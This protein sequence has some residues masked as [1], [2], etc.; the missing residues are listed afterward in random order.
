MAIPAVFH[1][2]PLQLFLME[3]APLMKLHG[4]N[5][6]VRLQKK[7]EDNSFSQVFSGAEFTEVGAGQ[8]WLVDLKRRQ[9]RIASAFLFFEFGRI[10]DKHGLQSHFTLCW[11]TIL[12]FSVPGTLIARSPVEW[13]GGPLVCRRNCS[14]CGSSSWNIW[15]R[16]VLW[17]RFG[18]TWLCRSDSR[19]R[20]G[21]LVWQWFVKVTRKITET[22]FV[23]GRN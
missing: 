6:L 23:G 1:L 12:R 10:A 15:S 8:L 9:F 19:S 5:Q 14:S 21:M 2:T 18:G 22:L 7:S 4:S 13:K 11:K 16:L 20:S 17:Q 3:L